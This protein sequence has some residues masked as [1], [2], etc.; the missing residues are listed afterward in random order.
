MRSLICQLLDW[1][2]RWKATLSGRWTPLVLLGMA[3]LAYGLWWGQVGFYWDDLP[4]SWIRYELGQ[5]ASRLYFS[6]NRPVWGELYQFSGRVLPHQP[7]PWQIFALFWRWLGAVVFW[8]LM[9]RL[10]PDQERSAFLAA[11]LFLLYPGHTLQWVAFLSSHMFI[12]LFFFLASQWMMVRSFLARR[13]TVLWTVGALVFSAANLWMME[14]YFTLEWIRPFLIGSFLIWRRLQDDRSLRLSRLVV[15][16]GRRWWPYLMVW[17][18]NGLYRQFVFNNTVYQNVLFTHLRLD[19]WG[20]LL[21]IVRHVTNDVILVTFGAWRQVLRWPRPELDGWRVTVL[22]WGVVT[23][24]AI[25]V[26]LSLPVYAA[27]RRKALGIIGLGLLAV[28]L[29]SGPYLLTGL[30]VSL[31]F[32]AHRFTLS[33]MMGAALIMAGIIEGLPAR[34]RTVIALGLIALSAGRH[35][36]WGSDYAREWTLFRNLFW[37]MT[38]RAP[39]LIPHTTVLLNDRALLSPSATGVLPPVNARVFNYYAD[40]SLSAALN[41]VY[42]PEARRDRI[43]YVLFYPKSRLGGSLPALDRG[44]PV[45]FDYIAG[46][47]QGNTSQIVAFYYAPPGCVRVL[48]PE[49]D[50]VNRFIPDETL[51]RQ[52]A[53]L[54]SWEWI[55]PW[56]SARPPE[57]LGPEPKRGWCY[58]F[59]RADLA[60][61]EGDWGEVVRL[62][63]VAFQ[64]NDH[65]NDPTERFVFIEGYAHVGDW[66]RAQDLSIEAWRVSKE[67]M[68]PMLCRLWARI[69]AQTPSDEAQRKAVAAMQARL[70]CER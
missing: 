17:L 42:D 43:R 18:A 56:G 2:S 41:W 30:E 28:V 47:F 25:L 12:V 64:L 46:T 5:E 45:R 9:R 60:R 14:Y 44:L 65:P 8:D 66:E 70:G 58:Y 63:E 26:Y 51:M 57:V 52:A 32:P 59:E 35:V 6:T 31:A 53:Q 11:A 39:G 36:W 24:I 13:W 27:R 61:Q 69:A 4:M 7:L 50:S 29:G 40:N 20:T 33:F 67:Y 54:S 1:L 62:A 55:T 19:P 10:W 48:D 16:I 37:Q 3:L 34:L 38:W 22:F 23:V 21:W 49:I 68:T 15:E